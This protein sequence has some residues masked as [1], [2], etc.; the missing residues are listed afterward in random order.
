MKNSDEI[1]EKIMG[2]SFPWVDSEMECK[3]L[4]RYISKEV[5][6]VLSKD[7]KGDVAIIT[8]YDIIQAI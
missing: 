2:N 7:A 5:P 1:V 8:Q 6:A 4:N 3:T